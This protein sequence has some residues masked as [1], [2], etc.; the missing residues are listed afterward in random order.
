MNAA[1]H[2]PLT[3]MAANTVLCSFPFV[4]TTPFW[5]KQLG[6]DREEAMRVGVCLVV[7]EFL[8]MG[9]I[10]GFAVKVCHFTTSFFNNQSSGCVIPYILHISAEEIVFREMRK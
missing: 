3:L 5:Q 9:P 10:Q 2:W 4:A 8:P 7:S 1:I 6:S